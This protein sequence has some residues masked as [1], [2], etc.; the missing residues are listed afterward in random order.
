MQG[1][2]VQRLPVRTVRRLQEHVVFEHEAGVATTP[3]AAA[4]LRYSSGGNASHDGLSASS[5]A[6]SQPVSSARPEAAS[7]ASPCA[8]ICAGSSAAGM[9]GGGK[10][11]V[12]RTLRLD[13]KQK[14]A[15]AG[16]W[17]MAAPDGFEPPN[18]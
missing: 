1:V 15:E 3:V 11:A 6:G 2:V 12:M 16:F 5:A 10:L 14:P 9:L 17:R 18:A 4:V 13:A 8:R 7:T